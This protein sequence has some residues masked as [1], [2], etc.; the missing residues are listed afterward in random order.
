[1]TDFVRES[2]LVRSHHA[3]LFLSLYYR[4]YEYGTVHALECVFH[5]N[6]AGHGGAI[7]VG[8]GGSGSNFF[9]I[10]T[11]YIHNF[12]SYDYLVNK[13]SGLRG[14]AIRAWEGGY[15][16]NVVFVGSMTRFVGNG[17]MTKNSGV[18]EGSTGHT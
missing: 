3:S 15:N 6:I 5:D 8:G 7:Y 13:G 14:G 9:S 17:L 1:M 11:S 2:R 12:A 18:Y 16:I 10:N 4:T